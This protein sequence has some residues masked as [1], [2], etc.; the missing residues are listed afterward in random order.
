MAT[1][2]VEWI[3]AWAGPNCYS[4]CG[5]IL[6][7]VASLLNKYLPMKI[8]I[9]K[10]RNISRIRARESSTR[11]HRL[12]IDWTRLRST[13]FASCSHRLGI[14][15]IHKM[16]PPPHSLAGRMRRRLKLTKPMMTS[17]LQDHDMLQ[18]GLLNKCV[19]IIVIFHPECE[20]PVF[21]D[22]GKSR[23]I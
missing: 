19:K 10:W 9:R 4:V 7:V 16:D 1:R 8:A 12:E 14:Q 15:P 11:V 3:H 5:L 2:R 17:G 6:G 22:L 18:A 21:G 23:T 20:E 13:L